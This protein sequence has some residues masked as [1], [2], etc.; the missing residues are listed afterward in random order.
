M[1]V[2]VAEMLKMSQA[3]L[4]DLF[5]QSPVGEIPTGEAKGTAIIAPGT[6]YTHFAWQGKIFDPAKGTLR[7][8]I[9]PFGLNAIIAKVYKGPSWM[10]EKECI[11]LDYSETSLVAHWIRDE[12][13][14]VAPRVYLGKVY[15]GKKRLID[16]ALEFPAAG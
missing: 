10:D 15:L 7:N 11:V 3:Q 12:I 8:K 2:T 9:L 1:A 13:R 5:T 4:D 6:T 14:E 16:F